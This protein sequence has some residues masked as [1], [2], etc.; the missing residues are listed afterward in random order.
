MLH[1]HIDELDDEVFTPEE[2]EL[3]MCLQLDRWGEVSL[4]LDDTYS[5]L[6]YESGSSQLC[7]DPLGSPRGAHGAGPAAVDGDPVAT[8][9]E[10]T[11]GPHR[12]WPGRG[13]HSQIRPAGHLGPGCGDLSHRSLSARD[14]FCI[15]AARELATPAPVPF[16]MPLPEPGAEI[17]QFLTTFLQGPT[18]PIGPVLR[19][20]SAGQASG[21]PCRAD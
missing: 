7:R 14:C 5:V 3:Q 2:E 6:G 19:S 13:C 18:P 12:F 17:G 20:G 15:L 16:P 4:V 21:W 11:P 8:T 9:A 1:I 10:G